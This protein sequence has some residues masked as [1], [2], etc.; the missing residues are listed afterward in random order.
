MRVSILCLLGIAL[1]SSFANAQS[2]EEIL[3]F[4]RETGLTFSTIEGDSIL[5]VGSELVKEVYGSLGIP[6][7]IEIMPG[8]RALQQA[9]VGNVDGEVVRT[10][11][12]QEL[13]PTLIRLSP[14]IIKGSGSVLVKKGRN[15][16]VNGWPSISEYKV[17]VT[18]GIQYTEDGVKDFQHNHVVNTD[19]A[20]I[21]ILRLGRADL[22]VTTR[23]N[24]LYLLNKMNLQDEID[25]LSPPIETF[26]LYNYLHVKHK[27]LVPIVEDH[28]VQMTVSGELSQLRSRFK[29]EFWTNIELSQ[30]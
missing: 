8:K 24:G 7:T 27:A 16:D 14:H 30:E 23:F 28:L 2:D 26:R 25:I 10:V 4:Y 18:R 12:V 20:L 3:S 1:L 17:G 9:S 13:R 22:I 29:K 15:I 11:R 5:K 6:V 21:E 19:F